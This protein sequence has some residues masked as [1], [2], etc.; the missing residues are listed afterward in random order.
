MCPTGVGMDKRKK[1]YL[2]ESLYSK[3]IQEIAPYKTPIRFVRLG[4]PLLHPHL[5][6]FI[7]QAVN[8][9][10]PVH[11]NTNGSV[12][13]QKMMESFIRIPLTSIKF[14][15]QGVDEQSY[16]E[17]RNI[18][19]FKDLCNKIQQ[20]S[21]TRGD[22]L[23]P[24]IHVSTTTTSETDEQINKFTSFFRPLVDQVSV[25]KTVLEH[26]DL[27]NN[28]L[29]IEEKNR[30][31]QLKERESVSKIHPE[32]PE[33]FDKLSINS[34]GTVS[35]CCRDY[36]DL[37]IVGDF[38]KSTLKEIWSSETLNRY[39]ELLADMKHD[40]IPLCQSCYDYQN[41]HPPKR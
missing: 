38:N 30:L 7:E 11:L 26:I 8:Y 41:L 6:K 12:L 5:L 18:N 28:K 9:N 16:E 36:D 15:F 19:F 13:D 17:M 10:I 35:A 40:S 27:E 33:V 20:L 37:M 34:D 22:K 1:G 25:G 23:F 14:S 24:Y 32:C 2:N 4:E 39:R 21:L 31:A 29:K 3:L